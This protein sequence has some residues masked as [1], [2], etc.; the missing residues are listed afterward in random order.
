MPDGN[1]YDGR[2]LVDVANEENWQLPDYYKAPVE[3]LSMLDMEKT[4]RK[5]PPMRDD[6][7]HNYTAYGVY[8]VMTPSNRNTLANAAIYVGFPTIA[9]SDQGWEELDYRPGSDDRS[10]GLSFLAIRGQR[11]RLGD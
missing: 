4:E 3:Q 5:A 6:E 2:S 1:D 9:T 10:C 8:L 7:D 11:T